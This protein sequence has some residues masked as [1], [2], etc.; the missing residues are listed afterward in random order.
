MIGRITKVFKKLKPGQIVTIGFLSIVLLGALL[1]TLPFATIDRDSLGFIDA[2]F[3]ATSAVCVTGL[4]VV[5][6][7]VTFSLF[8]Q[9][10]IT[11]CQAK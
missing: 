2:L 7:G 10:V 11:V 9:I 4:T 6:T 1:L 5:N 3:T 8:G